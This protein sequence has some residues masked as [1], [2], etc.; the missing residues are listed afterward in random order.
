MTSGLSYPQP[1]FESPVYNPAFY[2]TFDASG[3]LTYEYAQTLYLDKNRLIYITGITPGTYSYASAQTNITSVGTLTGLTIGGNLSFTGASRSI[4]GLSAL[5]A[6]TLTGTLQTG[7]QPNIT[8]VGSLVNQQF[9]RFFITVDLLPATATLDAHNLLI[10]NK[11]DTTGVGCGIAFYGSA[12]ITLSTYTPGSSIVALKQ[13]AN[14]NTGMDLVFRSKSSIASAT[15]VPS[16]RKRIKTNGNILFGDTGDSDWNMLRTN[17]TT[18]DIVPTSK[19]HV[20]ATSDNLYGSW[21][22]TQEWWNDNAS[23]IKAGVIIFNEAGGSDTNGV[24]FGTYTNDPLRWFING[25]NSMVLNTSK[26]LAID[27]SSGPEATVHSGGMIWADQYFHSKN[28]ALNGIY[29]FRGSSYSTYTG[30]GS[31]ATTTPGVRFGSY[32]SSF[33]FCSYCGV[34]GGAYTNALDERLKRDIEPLPYGL[35]EIMRLKPCRYT[36]K[37]S[38][39]RAIGLIAQEVLPIIPEPVNVPDNPDELTEDG[40]LMFLNPYGIDLSSLV[41]LALRGIQ[42]Q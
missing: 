20:F 33:A 7:A 23:P 42:Q 17:K 37:Q 24:S 39:E 18:S 41:A 6:T 25:T 19:L 28:N 14:V 1:I 35:D 4:T 13:G 16:E 21:V 27:R 12:T 15:T 40:N 8:S 10:A 38:G 9:E 31:N 29:T 36:L 3:Y 22:R 34:Y 26:R 11:S 32:D 30:M 2:L 5:T